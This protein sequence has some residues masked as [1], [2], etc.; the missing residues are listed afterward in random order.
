MQKIQTI[1]QRIAE[2]ENYLELSRSELSDADVKNIGMALKDNHTLKGLHLYA[3]KISDAGAKDIARALKNNHTLTLLDLSFNKISNAGA[4]DISIALN[5]NSTLAVLDL[6][7]N[8]ISDHATKDIAMVLKNNYALTKLYLQYNQISDAGAKDI[9]SALKDNHTLR[10]HNLSSND[11][12]D[13]GAK[14]IARALNDNHTLT[15]LSLGKNE[16]CNPVNEDIKRLLCRNTTFQEKHSEALRYRDITSALLN[17]PEIDEACLFS[18]N[19][20]L[21]MA[22]EITEGLQNTGYNQTA[23]LSCEVNAVRATAHLRTGNI[24]AGIDI[25]VNKLQ[26]QPAEAVSLVIANLILDEQPLS[27]ENANRALI[28]ICL[29]GTTQYSTIQYNALQKL[30]GIEKFT[31]SQPLATLLGVDKVVSVLD[32]VILPYNSPMQI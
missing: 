15:K 9:A 13:A 25:Y 29:R 32:V 5:D 6:S 22:D 19:E 17:S 1:L 27:D 10:E 24:R 3:N 2:G 11:I 8:E 23:A 14:N 31:P 4:K 12:S 20:A 28:L 7:G 16:I 30:R 18:L 26:P 21:N